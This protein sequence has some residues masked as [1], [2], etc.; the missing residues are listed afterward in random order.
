[1]IDVRGLHFSYDKKKDFIRD[2]SF[3]VK[4]GEIFG[5]LGP[6]GAGKSTLQK[7][8]SGILRDYRGN[9]RVLNTEVKNRRENFYENIGMVFEYPNLYGKFTALENLLYFS[10]LYKSGE[11]DPLTLM[12][13]VGLAGDLHKKVS[14]Y[15]KGM[16][17]RL[18]FVR[19]ILHKPHLLFLDEPTSGLDPGYSRII[20]DLIMEQKKNGRTIILTTHNMH[21]AEELCDRVAFI[22]DGQIRALDTP[23]ALRA[24]KS[25]VQ[26]SYNFRD[27]EKEAAGSALLSTL[28]RDKEFM[29]RLNAGLLTGIHS[30]EP[31]LEDVFIELTGRYL[32]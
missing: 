9:I 28:H 1:M 20:K 32:K 30:K 15:S 12:E 26:V 19:A 2:I 22:V 21:D 16:K 27:G 3:E 11:V 23:H 14:G 18:A 5:F 17:M 7:N 6:S 24:V 4:E 10:S 13:R 25:G 29:N 31:T 8:L